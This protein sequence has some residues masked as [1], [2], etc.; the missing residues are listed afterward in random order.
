MQRSDSILHV[1]DLTNNELK[2]AFGRE[3]RGPGEFGFMQLYQTPFSDIF[4][5]D[6]NTNVVFRYGIDKEGQPIPKETIQSK[7]TG[8][9]SIL[10]AAFINDSL[11]VLSDALYMPEGNLD[12][13]SLQNESVIYIRCFLENHG[14]SI[15]LSL[16]AVHV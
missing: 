3:G 6:I 2:C 9:H 8:G 4:I 5:G 15:V 12:M 7:Y 11:Y 10:N 16:F 1:Y 13:L 14:G